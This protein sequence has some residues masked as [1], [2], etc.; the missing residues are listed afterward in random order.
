M[1]TAA[2]D[3]EKKSLSISEYILQ[4]NRT[5]G[6]YYGRIKGEV[7]S[8]KESG[9]AVYYTLKDKKQEAKLDCMTWLNVY[10]ANS[11]HLKVGDEV[12]VSGAP[13]IYAPYGRFNFKANTIEYAGEGDLKRAF[14]KLKAQLDTEGLLQESRKRALPFLP[15]K[16]GIITSMSSGVVIHDFSSNLDRHGY[17]I[18]TCDSKVEG[19]EAVL[20]ILAAIRTMAK[21]DI[22][23]LVIIRGGGA[24][25]SFQAFNTESVVRAVAAF[26]VPVITGIGHDVDVTLTQ[27]VADVGASTPTAVAATFNAQWE[28]LKSEIEA[29][30]A[31]T[32]GHFRNILHERSRLISDTSN[33]IIRNYEKQITAAQRIVSDASLRA[34]SLFR[35]LADRV[36]AANAGLQ[37]ALGVM[38]TTLRSQYTYLKK[39]TS[40]LTA[41]LSSDIEETK[42]EINNTGM[43]AA[44]RQ[45]HAIKTSEKSLKDFERL[46]SINDPARN[47]R[48]GYSLSYMNGKL[49]RQI[50]DIGIGDILRTQ[51]M[52][53]NL[54]S[55]V[56]ELK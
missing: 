49:V 15:K 26:K 23:V 31:S 55:E 6:T 11:L 4:L 13:E 25:E 44:L 24:P 52:N 3:T 51:L 27:L 41:R 39:T 21:R 1:D 19:K 28:G 48:L 30:E 36:H 20:D 12:I 17:K 5:L 56:K 40:S 45:H 33:T 16:I 34:T 29:A 43:R 2:I 14:D 10:K 42:K 47:L 32:L 38:R 9:S 54:I 18:F 35:N 22:E 37:S 8:V 53:G 46:I 50:Q 7:I